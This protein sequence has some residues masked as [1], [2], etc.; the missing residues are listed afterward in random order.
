ME[1]ETAAVSRPFDFIRRTDP[2][3]L[4]NFIQAEH[5]QT[6]ALVLAY[7]APEKASYILHSLPGDIQ[8][9]VARR[10]AIMDRTS[11][12]VLRELERVLE[13]KLSAQSSDEYHAA[14]GVESIVEILNMVGRDSEKKIIEALE[15]MD[16]ELAYEIKN[17]MFIFEDIVMLDDLSIMKILRE[18]DSSELAKALKSVD[19]EVQDKIFRNM[20]KRAATMLKEDMEYMGPIRLKDVEESQQKIISIIRNLEDSGKISTEHTSDFV[21]VGSPKNGFTFTDVISGMDIT[22]ILERIEYPVLVTALKLSPSWM[23]R[24]L[25][26]SMPLYKCCKFWWDIRLRSVLFEDVENA[27]EEIISTMGKSLKKTA[28]YLKA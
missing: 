2:A 25:S 22:A 10:I 19:T 4:L 23:F 20:S 15:D 6:I 13:K 1:E 3:Q 7:L 11:S 12:K 21:L 9:E 8:S 16:P 28:E 5:P 17:R 14:G 27:R 26:K 18:V 24:K